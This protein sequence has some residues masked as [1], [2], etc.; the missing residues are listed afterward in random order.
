MTSGSPD[1]LMQAR[2]ERPVLRWSFSTDA[3]LTDMRYARETG[4]V[5]AA[6]ESGGLYLLD[7]RGQVAALTRTGHQFRFV[8]FADTGTAGAVIV[9]ERQVAWLDRHLQF[10]WKRS[11]PDDAIGLAMDPY[12]THVII[13]LA[14]GHNVIYNTDKK[15]LLE[16]ES[17]RPL[18]Y[19]Q[20]TAATT[21]LLAAAD[22]GF[23]ARYTLQGD[24]DWSERLWST[25][26][27]LAVTG[28]GEMVVLAGLAH[29]VQV[30]DAQGASQGSFVLDGTASL[31]AASYNRRRIAA[32][33]LER[34]ITLLD[35][36]GTMRWLVQPPDDVIRLQI[37]P[38][39]DDVVIG[40]A[41]GRITRLDTAS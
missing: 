31:V 9:D 11:L 17:L 33:T 1:W 27:D 6:D 41:D 39:G 35:T 3:R 24:L 29:G 10:V 22:Y 20:W 26:S 16:F 30:Y 23:F 15:K 32:A 36:E 21:G 38:L 19:L 4:E 5:L 25:V 7:R 40:F 8:A 13:A 18:R 37:G 2:G 34:H 28:D 12:G 14:S